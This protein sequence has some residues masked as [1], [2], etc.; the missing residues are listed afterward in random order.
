LPNN[1]LKE[2]GIK[3]S[4]TIARVQKELV[5]AGFWEVV[6]T[7][8]LIQPGVFRWSDNWLRYNQKSLKKAEQAC[9]G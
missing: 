5:A 2:R 4:D 6:E 7:G 8:S 9:R 3:G 1:L